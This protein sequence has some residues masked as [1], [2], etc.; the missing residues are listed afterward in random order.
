VEFGPTPKEASYGK[1]EN[2]KKGREENQ[3]EENEESREGREG[4]VTASPTFEPPL[5]AVRP[6]E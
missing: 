4:N 5:M 6:F 1:K 3:Q 2:K